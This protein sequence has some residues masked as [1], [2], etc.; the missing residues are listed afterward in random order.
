MKTKFDG[1]IFDMDGVLVDVSRSYREAIRQ[2][3]SYFLER[4]VLMSEVD[5]IKSKVEMNNDWDA[6]YALINNPTISYEG[7]KSY[8]QSIYLG[9]DQK[10]GLINNERLL[11]SKQK[12]QSLKNKYKKLG[13]ATGR[14]KIEAK[15]VINKNQLSTLF[16]CV[17][18]LED[19]VNSKPS[20]DS[21]RMVIEKLNLKQTVYIGDS[22][23]HVIAAERAK[24]PSIFVGKQ[25]IGTI[26]F[27]TMLEVVQ[28][29]L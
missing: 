17:I 4:S 9:N 2:T 10:S 29:L 18:A 20:P 16:D 27:Q 23:S 22:P 6:T 19:V 25:N 1:L 21:I 13:I 8:F 28:Y 5:E 7:V 24:I 14:P 26:R 15:Y 3:A 12:L 11:I